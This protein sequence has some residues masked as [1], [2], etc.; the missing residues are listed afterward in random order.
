MD[1]ARLIYADSE[2][3]ADLYYAT[4]FFAPDPFLFLQ[5]P[6]GQSHVVVS[7]LEVDRA[8][9]TARADQIH[10]WGEIKTRWQAAH[11]EDPNPGTEALTAFWLQELS[12]TSLRTPR[13]FPLL[14]ADRLRAADIALHP[15]SEPFWPQ[16]AIKTAEEIAHIAVALAVT[17]LGME[18][19]IDTIRQSTIDD[20]GALW[21]DGAPLTSERVRGEI[22]ARL[23]RE[24]AS[25]RHTIVAGGTQGADPHEEGHGPLYAGQ[26]IILDIF[27]RME[28]SGYWGDMT[29]TVCKGTPPKRL[30]AMWE[31]VQA[32]Q[33]VAFEL[34]RDQASGAEV[35]QAVTDALTDA[36][37]ITGTDE[38]GRQIGFF[39]GTG[40]G[41]GLEIHESPRIG[42]RDQT[43]QNGHVVTV[44]PGLYY[45]DLGG[46]RL[47]D[48][49]VV[50]EDGCRNLTRFPKF[51]EV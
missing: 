40:H 20:E 13:D 37:F 46:V 49:V 22:H 42:A 35:H 12:I 39:H 21:L 45:P 27:P 38:S 16:R 41:L 32:A 34:I 7:A 47:E 14:M 23:V 31:A 9:R 50:D 10:E 24:G 43:L 1:V 2:S 33:E 6:S 18:T 48:V 11:P 25:P 15:E 19:G 17:G 28:T 26:P 8:R 4:R 3:S 29:R 51:L 36:G 44:E 5:D 30:V